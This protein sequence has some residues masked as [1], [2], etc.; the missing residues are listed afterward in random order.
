VVQLGRRRS[1]L[2]GKL[3]HAVTLPAL[4]LFGWGAGFGIW[5][6][7]GLGVAAG[8]LLYEHRLV[9]ADDLSRLDAA[10]F[11]MNGVISVSFFAFVLA[12][13]LA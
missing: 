9:R 6:Y 3:L 1:I 8:I 10:F 5:Y 7:A 12:D 11:T 4:A 2:A 13:V